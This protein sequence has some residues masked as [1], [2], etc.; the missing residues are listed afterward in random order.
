M[1]R[2]LRAEIRD[3]KRIELVALDLAT[4]VLQV[5]GP[6]GAGKS[7][8]LDAV[9]AALGGARYTPREPIRRGAQRSRVVI[10]TETLVIERVWTAKADR[11][12]V[13][14]RDGEPVTRPQEHLDDLLGPLAFDPIAFAELPP[15]EQRATLLRLV[16]VDFTPLDA[17]RAELYQQRRDCARDLRA[18]QA[19]LGRAP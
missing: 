17:E 18:E 15:A 3:F 12:V 5:A 2:L 11:L 19:R 10:E 4:G 9:E 13:R 14:S 7:S 16:G 1:S 8:V 6:N